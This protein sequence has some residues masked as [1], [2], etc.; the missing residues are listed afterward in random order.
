MVIQIIMNKLVLLLLLVFSSAY[1]INADEWSVIEISGNLDLK[2]IEE[3]RFYPFENLAEDASLVQVI[4][5]DENGQFAFTYSLC[6]PVNAVL[7]LGEKMYMVFL[8]PDHNLKISINQNYE[9]TILDDCRLNNTIFLEYQ[10]KFSPFFNSD[11]N[12]QLSPEQFVSQVDSVSD[13]KRN[14]LSRNQ[15]KISDQLIDYLENDIAYGAAKEKIYFARRFASHLM[16]D[17]SIYFKFLENIS[18]QNEKAVHVYNYLN[19]IDNYINYLFYKEFIGTGVEYK[20]DYVEKYYIAR[21]PLKGVILEQFLAENFSIALKIRSPLS[22]DSTFQVLLNEFIENNNSVV[23]KNILKRAIYETQNSAV[24]IGKSSPNFTLM[25]RNN[26]AYTLSSFKDKYIVLDFWASWCGPCRREIPEMIELSMKYKNYVD[27]IFISIDDN[28]KNWENACNQ[29]EIP[30]PCLL[31]DN[32]TRTNYGFNKTVGIPYYIIIDSNG[33]VLS[34]I[35]TLEEIE[36]T[37]SKE[38]K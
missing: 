6:T 4:K 1:R 17:N 10:N 26:K 37:I 8:L 34:D 23:L 33:F 38:N 29:L 32:I 36:S 24:S 11:L 16:K 7:F 5:I 28:Q 20:N 18:I 3:L 2:N 13:L 22:K 25:N 31:I 27:V 19:F 30:E 15:N 35:T 12:Y 21:K 9:I 14:F